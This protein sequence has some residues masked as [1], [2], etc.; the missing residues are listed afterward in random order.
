L[1]PHVLR[2]QRVRPKKY[3]AKVPWEK[4]TA[5]SKYA[6]QCLEFKDLA[7]TNMRSIDAA[8]ENFGGDINC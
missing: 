8:L 1:W 2:L 6:V 4:I 7:A 3:A 5:P